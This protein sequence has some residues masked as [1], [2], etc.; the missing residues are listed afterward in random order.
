M[1]GRVIGTVDA[2][3]AH[4]TVHAGAGDVHQGAN[5]PSVRELDLAEALA[6]VERA[7][8][9]WT[10][11]ARELSTVDLVETTASASWGPIEVAFG[12][13]DVTAQVG[14]VGAH[15]GY[16]AAVLESAAQG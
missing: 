3:A 5:P 15:Q 4:R 2:G 13:V 12:T 6:L 16:A 7:Q 11:Y 1:T 9:E 14:L 8:P 10:T